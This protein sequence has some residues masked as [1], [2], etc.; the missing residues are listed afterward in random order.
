MDVR[1]YCQRSRRDSRIQLNDEKAKVD[2]KGCIDRKLDLACH[3]SLFFSL[4]PLFIIDAKKLVYKLILSAIELPK[5]ACIALWVI[6][7][8]LFFCYV[9]ASSG[10][11]VERVVD[12]LHDGVLQ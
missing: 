7:L 6:V 11:E 1:P 2:Y 4:G 9:F 3:T 5:Q 8:D 12:F 10:C